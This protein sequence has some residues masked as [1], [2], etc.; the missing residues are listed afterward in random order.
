MKKRIGH[1]QEAGE[2]RLLMTWITK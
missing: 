1:I 2:S